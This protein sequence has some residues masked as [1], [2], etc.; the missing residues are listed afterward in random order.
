[1]KRF[2][3]AVFFVFIL[4]TIHAQRSG[5]RPK[6]GLTLSG[7]GAKGLAHIGILKAIDS[8][9]LKV[10]IV[11]GTSMG[12][13]V[14]ALYSI[15]Y[16]ADTIEKIA[17]KIDWDILLSNASS[18]S[19]LM[20]LE[21]EE[22]GKYAIELPFIGNKFHLPSG[23]LESEEL[24]LKFSEFFFPV[25]N[26]KDF[27]K[28]SKSFKC[29]ATDVSTGDAVVF[30]KGD[31]VSAI[32]SSMAIPSVFTAVDYNGHKLVDGGIVRNFPVSD[33]KKMGA[34]FIIG[35]NVTGGL[36]PKEKIKN[37]FQILLQIA[38][39]REDADS[40]KEKKLCYIYVGHDLDNYTMGSFAFANE[41]IDE[42]IEKGKEAFPEIKALADSLNRIYGK[43]KWVAQSLPDIDSV[44]IT[45][46]EI[47]GL[48]HTTP[49]FFMHRMQFKNPDWYTAKQLS[50]H[51][52]KAFGTRY[53][54]KIIYSLV[55]L[56][57]GSCKII[58]QVEEN[59][60][61]FAKLGINYNT[62]TGVSLIGNIT[63][64]NFF[65]PY[66]RSLA[67]L[68]FGEN[69]RIRGE[70]LQFFGKYK[71]ISVS[72]SVLLESLNFNTY[73]NFKKD[74]VYKQ[75]S[76]A[77]DMNLRFTIKRKYSFGI[78]TQFDAYQY[79]PTIPSELEFRGWGNQFNTYSLLEM[80]TL[81]NSVYPKKGSRIK[82]QAGFVF[83]QHT[84]I[85][86]YF[87]GHLINNID[88]LGYGY[89]NFLNAQIRSEH[90]IPIARRYTLLTQFQAGIN[91]NQKENQYNSFYIGGLTP[92]FRN[93][94]VFAG[95]NEG[96]I[97]TGSAASFQLGLRF[98]A[99]SN[100]LPDRE[101]KRTLL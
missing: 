23:V 7:G 80:N 28:F 96:S 78:G 57:D 82:L 72:S 43:E 8:A 47:H 49:E 71:T 44:K 10:D 73:K 92:S 64:R 50:D 45:D 58:F 5:Q 41:I 66:S 39:F 88:S 69:M 26:I 101:S 30:D 48:D 13:I 87:N 25:Y 15:G 91:F 18:L 52:R 89:Q 20:M 77:G 35:S 54:R 97:V 6:V 17:R 65:T 90:Y 4:I 53:Y 94:I 38:F 16:S 63:T 61:T 2:C 83:D 56:N 59:P 12:S 84:D 93:Q 99:F 74:G 37:I 76:F 32:R 79:K 3:T 42:G 85:N 51:I 14:G 22:Y 75:R 1:M 11:T 31:I 46:F 86:Y 24:W 40:K 62:F 67:T 100:S 60:L 29:I 55:P 33:A 27:S 98:Q 19:S 81:S 34:D 95:L 9:Q 21:K 36:L 68:N 70:H